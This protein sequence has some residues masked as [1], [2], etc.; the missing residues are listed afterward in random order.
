MI[1]LLKKWFSSLSLNDEGIKTTATISHLWTNIGTQAHNNCQS[2]K[3]LLL[4]LQSSSPLHAQALKGSFREGVTE[5]FAD[6]AIALDIR[7]IR[8]FSSQFWASYSAMQIK[9]ECWVN[10]NLNDGHILAWLFRCLDW[11][12]QW[13]SSF[14]SNNLLWSVHV[15]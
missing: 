8:R 4:M 11:E 14:F 12:T 15:L 3:P 1:L 7:R 9:C 6:A 5:M 13:V 2:D 10:L